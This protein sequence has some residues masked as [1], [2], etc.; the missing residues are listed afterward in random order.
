VAKD[1]A[2]DGVFMLRAFAGEGILSGYCGKGQKNAE[3][4]GGCNKLILLEM[5]SI[6]AAGL[7]LPLLFMFPC[8]HINLVLHQH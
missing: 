3:G 4:D 5:C 2:K 6:R 1:P 8:N 7:P